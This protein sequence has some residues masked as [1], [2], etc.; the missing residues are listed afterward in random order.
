MEGPGEKVAAAM[1]RP[2][3]KPVRI[4]MV[5]DYPLVRA[6]L[7]EILDGQQDMEVVEEAGDD[8]EAV[9]LARTLRPDVVVMYVHMPHLNGLAATRRIVAAGLACRVLIVASEDL[10]QYR[11]AAQEA[12]ASGVVVESC[13]SAEL[14]GTVRAISRGKS[15]FRSAP[16][17]E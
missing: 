13:P 3:S 6:A 14:L 4:L 15:F 16:A 7:A 2:K 1:R 8:A 9:Q 5:H 12:G 11:K 10:E 17:S